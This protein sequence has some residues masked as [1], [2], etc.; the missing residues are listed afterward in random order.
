ME[1]YIK[2]I[3]ANQKTKYIICMQAYLNGNYYA[4]RR[5]RK[6]LYITISAL[7]TMYQFS[8]LDPNMD[9]NS[10]KILTHA[11]NDLETMMLEVL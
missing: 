6:D 8:K 2:S 1:T 11:M 4:L 7:N 10:E 3:V 9:P 5:L